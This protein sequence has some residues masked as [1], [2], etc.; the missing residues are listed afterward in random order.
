MKGEASTTYLT[1]YQPGQTAGR[2]HDLLPMVKLVA[3]LRHPVDRAYSAFTDMRSRGLE[4]I[5]D[6]REALAA[7]RE[8]TTANWRPGFRYWQNGLYAQNLAPYY[9]RF[10]PERI[11]I[12]LYEDWRDTP[13]TM[14]ADLCTFLG[15]APCSAM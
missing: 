9:E 12:Y 14:L 15:I 3:V 5:T 7:E 13:M 11:R 4:P 6:F 8:R 2:I 1:S 10:P